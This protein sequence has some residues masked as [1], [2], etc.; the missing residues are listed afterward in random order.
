VAVVRLRPAAPSDARPLTE[1]FLR[2]RSTAMPWLVSPHDEADTH[3]WMQHV[4]LPGQLVWVAEVVRVHGPERPDGFL[5][6]DGAWVEH[7]YVEPRAQRA[8]VGTA[9]LDAAKEH[10]PSRLWLHVFTRNV[11]ARRF[12][13]RAGFSLVESS[14]G[15]GN[16][17]KEPDC[18]HRWP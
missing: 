17:E 12:Y 16:E 15:S 2:S 11:P 13:E 14:D 6:M 1:L 10:S 18:T 4:V 3:G 7:L 9:L 8:G 5:A